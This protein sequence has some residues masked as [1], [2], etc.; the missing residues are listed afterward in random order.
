MNNLWLPCKFRS[1]NS[2]IDTK[3]ILLEDKEESKHKMYDDEDGDMGAP[4]YTNQDVDANDRKFTRI[5]QQ[6][7]MERMGGMK[8]EQVLL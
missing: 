2:P 8:T 5:N 1:K 6:E 7:N 3:Q 4:Q